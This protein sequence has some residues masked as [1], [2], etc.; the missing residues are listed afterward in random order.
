[1]IHLE[2]GVMLTV[3]ALN[4]AQN[5]PFL[6]HGGTEI[7]GAVGSTAE[8]EYDD[9]VGPLTSALMLGTINNLPSSQATFEAYTDNTL[10]GTW[11]APSPTQVNNAIDR[12]AKAVNFLLG[13]PI[14]L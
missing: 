11:A 9:T 3:Y 6:L 8:W 2:A 10:P 5:F 14:P 13:G 12:L 1:V 7:G 4:A